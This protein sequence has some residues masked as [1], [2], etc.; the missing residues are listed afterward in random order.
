MSRIVIL[1]YEQMT[2]IHNTTNSPLRV[3]SV[4]SM[5]V[6]IQDRKMDTDLVC[7]L[8]FFCFSSHN[9]FTLNTSVQ[10]NI[11]DYACSRKCYVH[12]WLVW[13]A[14]MGYAFP[15]RLS[16]FWLFLITCR[17]YYFHNNLSTI[18]E[19]RSEYVKGS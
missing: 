13:A 1:V 14:V 19:T 11:T 18:S 12:H 8:R 9:A 2:E 10:P 16:Y 15:V 17:D 4:I 3:Y 7:S 6:T 5:V